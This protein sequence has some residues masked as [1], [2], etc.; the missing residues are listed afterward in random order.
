MITAC[1]S[2][3]LWKSLNMGFTWL[4]AGSEI[5]KQNKTKQN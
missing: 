2:L 4:G 3:Y 5:K 1:I